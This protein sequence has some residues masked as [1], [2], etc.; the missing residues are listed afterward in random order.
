MG[1]AVPHIAR[2]GPDFC[3]MGLIFAEWAGILFT[4]GYG[5][6]RQALEYGGLDG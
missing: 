4:Y 6:G 1:R 3:G 5:V 2:N